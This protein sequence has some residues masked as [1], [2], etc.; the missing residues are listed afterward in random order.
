MIYEDEYSTTEKK[1]NYNSKVF[2]V[3]TNISACSSEVTGYKRKCKYILLIISCYKYSYK[4]HKQ[5]ELWLDN[6]MEYCRKNDIDM[7]YFVVLGEPEASN[8][9]I[10]YT[11]HYY[12]HILQVNIKDDYISLPKK[13][14]KAYQAVNET[15]EYQHIFKMDDDQVLLNFKLFDVI[16]GTLD[17]VWNK[18]ENEVYCV[19]KDPSSVKH[20]SFMYDY[21]GQI[22]DVKQSYLSNSHLLHPEMPKFLP[23]YATTYCSGPFYFLSCQA[24]SYLLKYKRTEIES[25]YFEDYAIGF[26]LHSFFKKNIMNIDRSKYFRELKDK[27][28]V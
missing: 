21:G 5:K 7:E 10:D 25:E 18:K 4:I 20:Y 6:F 1:I 2:C 15:Y 22:V 24:V 27:E 23:V 13:V 12:S 19:G 17:R 26:H 9:E 14:V 16:T 28:C 3:N 11:F 8:S